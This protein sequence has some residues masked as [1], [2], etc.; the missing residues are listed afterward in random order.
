MPGTTVHDLDGPHR[1]DCV[2]SVDTDRGEIE[3]AESP[4][5]VVGGEIAR[6]VLRYQSVWPICGR[7]PGV[8]VLFHC[9]TRL[10]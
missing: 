7:L 2:F 8:P 6:K 4:M 10:N 1:I 3:V 9:H 5:Q